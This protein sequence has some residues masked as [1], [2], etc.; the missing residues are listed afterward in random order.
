[1]EGGDK[2]FCAMAISR[3]SGSSVRSAKT[4]HAQVQFPETDGKRSKRRIRKGRRPDFRTKIYHT[5]DP[6]GYLD[7]LNS[8][9]GGPSKASTHAYSLVAVS[10]PF[11]T[12][13][14]ARVFERIWRFKS[15]G[16]TPRALWGRTVAGH[17]G[18]N[19]WMS[20]GVLFGFDHVC[21][22][23]EDSGDVYLCL[24]RQGQPSTQGKPQEPFVTAIVP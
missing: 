23:H 16:A 12:E 15:R 21:V 17:F 2:W 18:S 9:G 24:R 14:D 6:T 7:R 22:H 4:Q 5:R 3:S 20:P 11:A 8:S 19:W 13:D 10:G 1:M